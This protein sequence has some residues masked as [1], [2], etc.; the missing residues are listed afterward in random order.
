M[1]NDI[2]DEVDERGYDSQVII[3]GGSDMELAW[4]DPEDTREWCE[5]YDSEA[6]GFYYNYGDAAGCTTSTTYD[7]EEDYPCDNGWMISDIFY[8][9]LQPMRFLRF[10]LLPWQE[11]GKT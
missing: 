3:Y 8:K 1:V 5:G 2:D 4:D 6:A 10:I 9:F 11:S 7:G